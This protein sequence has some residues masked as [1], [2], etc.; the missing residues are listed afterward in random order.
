M[1]SVLKKGGEKG[2]IWMTLSGILD[3]ICSIFFII[4]PFRMTFAY[5]M[6]MGLYLLMGGITLL[7]Q[8]LTK[9]KK[10]PVPAE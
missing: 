8:L 2:T 6:I 5:E 10:E 7:F 4:A 1:A 9:P 3:L